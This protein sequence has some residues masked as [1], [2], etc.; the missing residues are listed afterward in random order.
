MPSEQAVLDALR[1]VTDPE[2]QTDIVSLGL[3]QDLAIRDSDVSFT[4]AF[5]SQAPAARAR[6]HSLATRA[7]SQLPGVTRVFPPHVRVKYS[8]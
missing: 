2:V 1:T 7:V 6:L 5:T 8:T 3:I 4:L